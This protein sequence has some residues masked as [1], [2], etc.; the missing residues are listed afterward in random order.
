[1]TNRLDALLEEMKK[2]ALDEMLITSPANVYYASNHYSDPHE[3]VLAVY[4]S[5]EHDPYLII[6][7][8]EAEDA[9]QSGWHFGMISYQDHENPWELFAG[10]LKK[11]GSIPETLGVEHNHLTLDRFQ[12]VK[13]ILPD[14]QIRDAQEILANLR[15][16]KNKKEY[17]MLKQAAALA[18]LGI[19]TGIKAIRE[20]VSELEVVA[21]IEFELKKQGV[22]QMSFSTMAIS[23]TK[24]A[25]PHGDR[26]SVV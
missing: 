25:S 6:P 19:E 15:V 8:M 2:E 13:N 23:G 20:G 17:T 21:A 1:M 14:T 12:Q 3:R 10:M 18:D 4:I 11:N 24:T 7:A 22:Q 16:I 26:K 5:T 9:K